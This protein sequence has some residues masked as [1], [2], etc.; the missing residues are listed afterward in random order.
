MENIR[1][2]NREEFT[3]AIELR[4]VSHTY[5]GGTTWTIRD[6]NLLIENET[7][8]GEFV[9][10]LGLSGCGK[11]TLLRF[12]AGLAKPTKGQV[13]IGGK[14]RTDR[15]VISMVFQQYSSLP[16]YT[17][18]DNV[19][20]ALRYQGVPRKEKYERAREMI[21]RVGLAGHEHKYSTELSGGQLQRVAIARSLVSNPGM[22]LMDEPFGALDVVTRY[23]MQMLV[24]DLFES[25]QPTI[26]FITHDI[27]EAVFLANR[28]YVM[29]PRPGRITHKIDVDPVLSWHRDKSTLRDPAFTDL[30][31]EVD[32][33]LAA[34]VNN[35]KF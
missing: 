11:S 10:L 32:A 3:D 4:D 19:A 14:P 30:V 28:I 21:R 27:R 25:I 24:N 26:I 29:S 15:D 20:L 17:V 23:E 9:V 18:L 1:F 34:T 2:V 22:V 16:W 31:H 5:D 35:A 13:L 12:I 8:K 6:C 7:G 33:A